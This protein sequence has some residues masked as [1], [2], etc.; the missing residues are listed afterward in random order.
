MKKKQ[1]INSTNKADFFG[2]LKRAALTPDP[3]IHKKSASQTVSDYSE[4]QT[5][6][7]SS[8]SA[9][10]KRGGKSR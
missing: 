8:A 2:V 6:S 1:K 3:T 9:A 7:H 4:T 10:S 5:H